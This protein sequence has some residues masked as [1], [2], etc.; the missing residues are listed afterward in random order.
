MVPSD[1]ILRSGHG[2]AVAAPVAL[3]RTIPPA[4]GTDPYGEVV[5]W[6]IRPCMEVAAAL[7]VKSNG[8][9]RIELGIKREHIAEV[10]TAS[11]EAA[12]R[13]VAPKMKA[14][15]PW[16]ARRAAY[17]ITLRLCLQQLPGMK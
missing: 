8:Q 7:D 13:D 1:V 9:D 15:G 17:P 5:E 10:M 12:T 14:G 16:E 6:V 3:A 11:R 4:Q 2:A